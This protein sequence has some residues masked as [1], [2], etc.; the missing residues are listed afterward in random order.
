MMI[1]RA[2]S[3][4]VNKSTLD[5]MHNDG[6]WKSLLSLCVQR[7]IYFLFVPTEPHKEQWENA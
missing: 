2:K 5:R 3:N 1:H 7:V 4:I 6:I